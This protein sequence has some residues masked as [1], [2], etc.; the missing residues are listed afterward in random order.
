MKSIGFV[1]RATA[2]GIAAVP[3]VVL[4]APEVDV[5]SE[6]TPGAEILTDVDSQW[7]APYVAPPDV[8][9]PESSREVPASAGFLAHT[10]YVI[11]I[12][13]N[14]PSGIQPRAISDLRQPAPAANPTPDATFAEYPASLACVYKMGKTYPGC[15]PVNNSA[16]N[17]T[18]GN[19]AIAIVIAYDNPTANADLNYFSS[20]FGLPAP[21][22][23]NR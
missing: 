11:A 9:V 20:F 22:F 16:Y 15:A 21:T 2:F 14:L 23:A 7:A 12:P 6:Q 5:N 8:Y 18:G 13:R 10:N 17:A 19:R 3:L 4:S 1:L